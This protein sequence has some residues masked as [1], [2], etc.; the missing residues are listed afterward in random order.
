[1]SRK[2]KEKKR[3]LQ[4]QARL[5]FYNRQLTN[6]KIAEALGCS[7]RTV[8]RWKFQSTI[9]IEKIASEP[10]RKRIRQR[11]YSVQIF[12][13]IRTLKEKNPTFSSPII[14]RQIQEEF[15]EPIPSES[16]IR[17]YLL[18]Q[19]FH[20]KQILNRQ[21][22]IKF[23]RDKPNELWQID[24]AGGQFL[25]GL[26]TVFLVLILDDCSRY[27]L[28]AQYFQD[29]KEMNVLQVI[30]DAVVTYGRPLELFSDNGTQ[31]KNTMGENHTRYL[32]LLF[33]LDIK[34]IFSK[35][36]H[37]QSKGK[38]E[39]IFETINQS[40]LMRLRGELNQDSPILLSE[41][42]NRFQIWMKWYNEEKPHR[43]LPHRK[44]PYQFYWDKEKRIYRPLESQVDWNQWINAYNA[45][46]VNKYNQI[47]FQTHH[48]TI[49][50]GYVGCWMDVL[51]LE[52]RFE[53]YHQSTL[54]CTY[55]KTADEYFPSL[56]P[57]TRI[58]AENG[59]IRYNCQ[60]YSIDYKLAGK[61]VEIQES[62]MGQTLLVYL[63][64]VL[65]KR[66]STK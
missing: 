1:M 54:L 62:D 16:T 48:I 28:T 51:H 26:G 21:G 7:V 25:Q 46:K 9:P 2:N 55:M 56:S 45:R 40:F 61:K 4:E 41:L 49:P 63:D 8:I 22:Y 14:F 38:I 44:P 35:K 19:G 27:I 6:S 47:Q 12:D 5:L 32:N 42:N 23:Q 50:P 13:R 29:Q 31:F 10:K 65:I 52:D 43:S 60:W 18:S 53:I 24:L 3:Q 57:E 20:F 59:I 64:K 17:K 37:P 11:H 36:N 15:K 66:L 34:P 39:R 30:K 58:I 33:S